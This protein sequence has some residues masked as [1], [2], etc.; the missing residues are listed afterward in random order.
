[1]KLNQRRI[2]EVI[3]GISDG[4]TKEAACQLVGISRATFYNW[5]SQGEDDAAAGR[6]TLK[7]QLFERI[8]V[9]EIKCE[10]WHLSNI[11]KGAE[12]DWRASGW[13]LE[14]TRHERYGRRFVQPEQEESSDELRVIG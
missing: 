5:L 12:R 8:P 11:R 3:Q 9:A 13:Y 4:L 14:R 2:D 7:R 10:K 6:R 1:M